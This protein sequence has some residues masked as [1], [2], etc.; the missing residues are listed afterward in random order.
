MNAQWSSDVTTVMIDP[1]NDGPVSEPSTFAAP[2]AACAFTPDTSTTYTLV[3]AV[4]RRSLSSWVSAMP[5]GADPSM[6]NPASTTL[7]PS[8]CRTATPLDPDVRCAETKS[9][10]P[11]A[12][13]T[14]SKGR[15]AIGTRVTAE[16]SRPSHAG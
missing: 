10:Q 7:P 4:T 1:T 2:A 3:P 5:A 14:A 13:A 12:V 15:S 11:S 8:R 16:A 6:M 9:Q